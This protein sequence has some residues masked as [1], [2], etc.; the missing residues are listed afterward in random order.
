[1]GLFSEL[2]GLKTEEENNIDFVKKFESRVHM[3]NIIVARKKREMIING[4]HSSPSHLKY[5]ED[6]YKDVASIC[7]NIPMV[8]S[9]IE[10][11]NDYKSILLLINSNDTLNFMPK[12]PTL[13]TNQTVVSEEDYNTIVQSSYFTAY[14]LGIY[15]Y[16]IFS[17]NIYL[18]CDF[19]NDKLIKLCSLIHSIFLYKNTNHREE[20]Y[21]YFIKAASNHNQYIEEGALEYESLIYG[22]GCGFS[23]SR[24]FSLI[25]NIKNN[26]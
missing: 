16:Y 2:F 23:P 17:K 1:M 13:F 3:E 5:L 11:N 26:S 9:K 15:Q 7:N 10:L 18:Y 24:L 6:Y 21:R 22:Q 19:D 4:T 12:L 25:K 14:C 8:T 20:L